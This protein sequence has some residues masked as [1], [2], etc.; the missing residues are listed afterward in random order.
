[1]TIRINGKALCNLGMIDQMVPQQPVVAP[2][3]GIR[4]DAEIDEGNGY[5]SVEGDFSGDYSGSY[6]GSDTASDSTSST[7]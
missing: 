1:M 3:D 6:T 5:A 7:C 2:A 4:G